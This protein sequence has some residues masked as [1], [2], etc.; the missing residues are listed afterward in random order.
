M[1]EID[2]QILNQHWDEPLHMQPPMMPTVAPTSQ[3]QYTTTNATS[4]EVE[5]PAEGQQPNLSKERWWDRDEKA[6]T[7]TTNQQVEPQQV[8][9]QGGQSLGMQE[10]R[11]DSYRAP[12]IRTV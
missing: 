10:K 4:R 8:E 6:S 2:D 5:V 1:K 12:T 11:V 7:L 3:I 9:S